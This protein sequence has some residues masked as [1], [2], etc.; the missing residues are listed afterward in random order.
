MVEITNRTRRLLLVQE[1]KRWLGFQESGGNNRGQLV[2]HFLKECAL[3]P[4]N[5]WCMAF[6]QSCVGQVERI[7]KIL[8]PGDPGARLANG[9]LCLAVWNGSP[10]EIRAQTPTIGSVAIWRKGDTQAGHTGIVSGVGVIGV[11]GTF[12]TIEGNTSSGLG[13]DREGD[14]VFEKTHSLAPAGSM[15]LLGFID[16]WGS[17][18]K[19]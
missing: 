16:P 10:A 12:R 14:G 13:V 17:G 3:A 11:N 15:K 18:L 9:G 1:A 4:G 7:L 19:H 5:P 2:E 8:N 6:V